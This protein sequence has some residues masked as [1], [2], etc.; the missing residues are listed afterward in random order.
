MAIILNIETATKNCSV[1]LAKNGKTIHIK[2]LND[3]KYSHAEKLHHFIDNLLKEAKITLNEVDAIAISKGPGSYT[4]LRIGVSSAKGL[5]FSVD[6]PLISVETLQSLANAINI[7]Y[8]L[9]VPMLDARRME[10]YASVFNHK[11]QQVREI[12]A[13]VIDE[14]SFKEELKQGKVYFLGDGAEKCKTVITH[15]NAIFVDHQFP[16]A[17]QMSALSYHKYLKNDFENVAYFE[18]FYLK[19]FVV[20]PAKKKI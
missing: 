16:S 14:N 8:G 10:V 17:E 12:K 3:G 4:G 6:K 5:C 19:D 20:T 9:I 13:E 7:E 11:H 18:P 2:E 1:S 15:Q